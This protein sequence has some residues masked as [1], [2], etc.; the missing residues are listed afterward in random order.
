MKVYISGPIKGKEDFNRY[1]FKQAEDFIRMNNFSPINPHNIPD[2]NKTYS[3]EDYMKMDIRALID[4]DMIYM[5]QGWEESKGAKLEHA[6]A[7]MIG[8]IIKYE[9]DKI[10]G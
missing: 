6:I 1:N 7:K 10:N 9:G 5:L 3:Y 4:C 8:L 2:P